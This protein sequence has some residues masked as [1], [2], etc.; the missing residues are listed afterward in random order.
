MSP[1]FGPETREP[2]LPVPRFLRHWWVGVLIAAFLIVPFFVKIPKGLNQHPIIGPFGDES[3]VAIFFAVTLLLYWKGPFRGRLWWAVG[4]S[5]VAG[6][7]IEFIQIPFGR[8]A[9]LKDFLLDLQGIGIVAAL[10]LW[11]G[12][13][14][15]WGR[16]AMVVLL[17][18]LPLL[19]WRLPFIASAASG[20]HDRFPMIADF[21]GRFDGWLW[22][23][24][25]AVDFEVEAVDD[26][27]AGPTRV[28]RLTGSPP[29]NWPGILIRRFQR[30]WTGYH[31]IA[32][33]VR[34]VEG[35]DEGA[36]LGLRLDDVRGAKMDV[37]ISKSFDIDREWQTIRFR[38]A[39]TELPWGDPRVFDHADLET[40]IFFLPKPQESTTIE[41]D[42]VRLIGNPPPTD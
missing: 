1:R 40:V 19:A 36:K 21:E 23:S 9:Q 41:I 12:D 32:A 4:A 13:R 34:V 42:N 39:D 17:A 26:G 3:H 5:V 27:P 22:I 11:R 35:P 7:L 10:I 18:T 15:P 8:Q 37:W 31:T 30:D 38:F 20:T 25:M 16:W 14:R 33:D 6:G 29:T 24:N 28:M 2:T